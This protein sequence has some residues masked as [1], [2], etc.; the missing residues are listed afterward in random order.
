[1]FSQIKYIK[2]IAHRSDFSLCDLGNTAGVRLGVLG[3][4]KLERGALRWR[5][6]DFSF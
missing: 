6:I 5:H 1:M 4:K 2:H 3:A